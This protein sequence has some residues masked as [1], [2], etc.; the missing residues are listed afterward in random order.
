MTG[1]HAAGASSTAKRQSQELSCRARRVL[2][3]VCQ[4]RKVS[5]VLLSSVLSSVM[6]AIA[7]DVT[8]VWSVRLTPMHP[9]K[10]ARRNLE[11]MLVWP[12]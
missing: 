10:T 3:E 8:V 7:T 5:H 1:Q 2:S 6:P 9:A 11:W 4:P 12:K